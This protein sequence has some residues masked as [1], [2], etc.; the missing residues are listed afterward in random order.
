MIIT[1]GLKSQWLITQGYGNAT[2]WVAPTYPITAALA[3]SR[4]SAS[5]TESG[6]TATHSDSR[7]TA[8]RS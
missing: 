6:L 3:D 7:L 8:R 1:Q 2:P 5:R 4:L